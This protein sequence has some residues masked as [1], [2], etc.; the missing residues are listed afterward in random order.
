[1]PHWLWTGIERSHA[2]SKLYALVN[3]HEYELE[4]RA[5]PKSGGEGKKVDGGGGR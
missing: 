5:D 2:M 4:D 3:G 1:M